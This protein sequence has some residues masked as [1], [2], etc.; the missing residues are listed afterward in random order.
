MRL[1]NFFLPCGCIHLFSWPQFVASSSSCHDQ[2]IANTI[3]LTMYFLHWVHITA[4]VWQALT[5]SSFSWNTDSVKT[6]YHVR[7]QGLRFFQSSTYRWE[8]RNYAR[9]CCFTPEGCCSTWRWVQN[10]LNLNWNLIS[11]FHSLEYILLFLYFR[12]KQYCDDNEI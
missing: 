6:F 1:S 4:K 2:V 7:M 9:F 5:V 8:S 10:H 12:E 3:C 11:V